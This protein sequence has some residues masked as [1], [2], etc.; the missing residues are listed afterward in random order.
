MPQFLFAATQKARDFCASKGNNLIG[1]YWGSVCES[2]IG[3]L[4]VVKMFWLWFS[5]L[6]FIGIRVKASSKCEWQSAYM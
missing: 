5:G 3:R 4:G 1:V 2:P 6:G